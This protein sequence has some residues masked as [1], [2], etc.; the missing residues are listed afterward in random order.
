M[1]L[2]I[3]ILF[4]LIVGLIAPTS[5][6]LAEDFAVDMGVSRE[7]IWFSPVEFFA[8]E[9]V[10]IYARIENTGS[11][12]ITGQ[13]AFYQG[14]HQIGGP[15]SV[16][17][18]A[19]GQSEEVWTNEWVAPEG[20]VNIKVAII[21]A[22]PMDENWDNN[23][24][25]SKT[26]NIKKDTD[27]DKIGDDEDLDDDGDGMPDEWELEYNFDPL[28]SSDGALDFD[29]D[30]LSN[31]EEY[32]TGTDPHKPDSD[33]DGVND[34]DDVFPL[35]SSETVDT[36][37]D[38]IGNNSDEDDDGDG[39]NDAQ[40]EYPLDASKSA[41]PQV[42]IVETKPSEEID[43]VGNPEPFQSSVSNDQEVEIVSDDTEED[44]DTD[45]VEIDISDIEDVVMYTEKTEDS[46]DTEDEKSDRSPIKKIT[47]GLTV[48]IGLLLTGMFIRELIRK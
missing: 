17:I 23:E 16:S 8:G 28:D 33:G 42:E 44:V 36:D 14:V 5:F 2:K 15:K 18:V 46:V 45:E 21:D 7:G 34:G 41:A 25:I 47:F 48:F 24:A 32:N 27:G 43:E 38:G 19:G 4:L 39:V 1:R 3:I 9:D 6:V 13:V 11:Q 29:N 26:F 35:D 40:D 20:R 10:R 30:G 12:D 37:D 31:L 22:D